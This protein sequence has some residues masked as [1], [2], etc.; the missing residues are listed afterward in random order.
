MIEKTL[1][2]HYDYDYDYDYGTINLTF[3][4]LQNNKL[5]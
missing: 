2:C 3:E 1:S 5:I 4:K